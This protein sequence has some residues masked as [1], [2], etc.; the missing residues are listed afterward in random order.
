MSRTGFGGGLPRIA[1]SQKF[2][3]DAVI[4]APHCAKRPT[5]LIM[6]KQVKGVFSHVATTEAAYDNDIG[7]SLSRTGVVHA[8]AGLVDSMHNARGGRRS[9]QPSRQFRHTT[10][11]R[12]S[13]RQQRRLFVA[14][15]S[16][17]L[18]ALV[19]ASIRR[20]IARYTPAS[21]FPAT[22]RPAACL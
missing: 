17:C 22:L 6:S 9:R 14:A 12:C 2:A 20:R 3:L 13:R 21:E 18:R 7:H 11:R 5:E 16:R 15:Q 1:Y 19:H 10:W 4:L 8:K